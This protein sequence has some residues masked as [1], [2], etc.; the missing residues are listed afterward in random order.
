M[1]IYLNIPNVVIR[2]QRPSLI[3]FATQ[4]IFGTFDVKG[5]AT[6]ASSSDNEIPTEARFKAAQS[7]A[8]SPQKLQ[9]KS[10]FSY[11]ST[12]CA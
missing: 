5:D 8:P 4:L 9:T 6:E 7:F 3:S 2:A 1:P 10:S 11:A 12:S